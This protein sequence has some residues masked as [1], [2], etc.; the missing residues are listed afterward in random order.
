MTFKFSVY[1]SLHYF[2]IFTKQYR[3]KLTWPYWHYSNMGL[4][5]MSSVK[6]LMAYICAPDIL[7][8]L[9]FFSWFLAQEGALWTNSFYV[10][11]WGKIMLGLPR[12]KFWKV[13]NVQHARFKLA[14]EHFARNSWFIHFKRLHNCSYLCQKQP[15]A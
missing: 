12:K 4:S 6:I 14:H 7:G 9:F 5:S 8:M 10:N 2:Q 11:N 1:S 3:Q 13:R 15:E